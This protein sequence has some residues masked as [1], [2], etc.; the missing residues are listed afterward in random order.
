MRPSGRL[1]SFLDN[2]VG[3][4]AI[5]IIIII[6]QELVYGFTH[7]RATDEQVYVQVA[8]TLRQR[9]A[10]SSQPPGNDADVIFTRRIAR[11]SS[12]IHCIYQLN[13]SVCICP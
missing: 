12:R 11:G 10:D 9:D 6:I 4:V 5:I 8:F 7:G 3:S 2:A 13:T 1:P